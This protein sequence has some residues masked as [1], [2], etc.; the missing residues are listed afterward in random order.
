MMT[1]VVVHLCVAEP[2]VRIFHYV[3]WRV[4]ERE[5]Q[6]YKG[7]WGQCPKWG[8]GAEPLVMG[9]GGQSPLKLKT[10]YHL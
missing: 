8:P 6:A 2:R 5:P 4:W 3:T 1:D 10:N 7:E 9:S